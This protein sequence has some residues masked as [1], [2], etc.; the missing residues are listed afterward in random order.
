MSWENITLLAI[1]FSLLGLNAV[2]GPRV[3]VGIARLFGKSAGREHV[4]YGTGW[5]EI[6]SESGPDSGS[7][8]HSISGVRLSA[9]G[10]LTPCDPPR[11]A[12]RV[13]GGR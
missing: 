13:G 4:P 9:T 3:A 12:R 6:A 5:D 8:D 1:G 10:E 11:V 2:L 7:G